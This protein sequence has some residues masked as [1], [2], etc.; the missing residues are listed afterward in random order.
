MVDD[1]PLRVVFLG[2]PEF[3]LPTLDAILLSRHTVVGVVT[4]P[5]RPRGRGQ[6]L[7]DAPVKL[8]AAAAGVPI[9]QPERLKDPGFLDALAGL[10]ADIGIVAA[11][12]KILNDKVLATPALG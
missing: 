3:A 11:Y 12:G 9:L 8:R 7:T 6:K 2:T 10:S 5:D 4:Q 1:A